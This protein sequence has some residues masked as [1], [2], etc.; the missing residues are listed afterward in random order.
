[1]VKVLPHVMRNINEFNIPAGNTSGYEILYFG[2][3]LILM[4][5]YRLSFDVQV[6]KNLNSSGEIEVLIIRR[7]DV[8]AWKNDSSSN[9]NQDVNLHY[10]KKGERINDTF[11]PSVSD[12]YAFILSN[13]FSHINDSYDD[14]KTKTVEATLIHTW[15]QEIKE[16]QLKSR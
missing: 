4:F 1:V 5:D 2:V 12:A 6:T 16:S 13:R 15:Q 3:N 9:S 7:K 8:R 11:K 14:Y 10:S